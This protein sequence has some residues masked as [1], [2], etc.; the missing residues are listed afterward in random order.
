M[1]EITSEYLRKNSIGVSCGTESEK[2]YS[3][4]S[5]EL[6]INFIDE[7]FNGI[8]TVDIE[9]NKVSKILAKLSHFT[10]NDDFIEKYFSKIE[11][12]II[13]EEL[14]IPDDFKELEGESIEFEM[15]AMEDISECDKMNIL[16]DTFSALVGLY[17]GSLVCY[18]HTD[19]LE[20]KSE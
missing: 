13:I 1:I 9:N 10:I 15:D 14:E 6:I 3:C 8:I 7:Y 18:V 11:G 19:Y 16:G 5:Q 12:D 4:L 17:D 2:K 20:F